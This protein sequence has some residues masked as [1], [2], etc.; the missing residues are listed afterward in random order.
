M[1]DNGKGIF[2]VLSSRALPR[3]PTREGIDKP[4]RFEILSEP[5]RQVGSE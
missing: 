4:Y 3:S 2:Y 5:V 1:E